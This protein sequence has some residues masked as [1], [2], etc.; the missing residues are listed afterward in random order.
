[1][2]NTLTIRN[3]E[4]ASMMARVRVKRFMDNFDKKW[5]EPNTKT[6]EAITWE[7]LSDEDKAKVRAANPDLYNRMEERNGTLEIT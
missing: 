5:N 4:N 3:K 1:M 7:K 6:L 2:D